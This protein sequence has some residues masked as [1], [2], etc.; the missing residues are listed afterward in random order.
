MA[1]R[2]RVS[3]GAAVVAGLA[4]GVVLGVGVAILIAAFTL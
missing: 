1:W 2:D 4:C 3:D